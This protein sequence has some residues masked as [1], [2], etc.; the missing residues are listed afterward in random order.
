MSANRRLAPRAH[1][2]IV[3]S[4]PAVPVSSYHVVDR[5]CFL[6]PRDQSSDVT[7]IIYTFF[8]TSWK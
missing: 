2:W 4:A 3:F 6:A 5:F 1:C 8:L 7:I